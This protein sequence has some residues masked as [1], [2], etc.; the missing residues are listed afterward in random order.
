MP[1]AQKGGP[2]GLIQYL[3]ACE[4]P[5]DMSDEQQLSI[6]LAEHVVV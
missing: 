4:F 3:A 6:G 5:A 2:G 1:R